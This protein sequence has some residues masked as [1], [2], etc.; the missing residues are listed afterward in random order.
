MESSTDK[1]KELITSLKLINHKLQFKG[2]VSGNEPVLIDYVP[3]LGD[4]LGYTSLELLLLSISSCVGSALLVV[5]RRMQKTITDFEI[6]SKGQR[7]K[8]HPTGFNSINLEIIMQS[9]DISIEVLEKVITQIEG[10]CPVLSMVKGNVL[11][12]YT[13]KITTS[14]EYSVSDNQ[15]G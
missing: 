13:Y 3:P 1:S 11:V 4:N 8:E 12:T 2:E 6:V 9:P 15:L 14:Y 5:L 10:L 7:K